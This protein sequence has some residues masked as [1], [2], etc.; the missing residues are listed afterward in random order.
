M[1]VDAY[2]R[3]LK[4]CIMIMIYQVCKFVGWLLLHSVDLIKLVDIH[5]SV[6]PFIHLSVCP[7][8]FFSDLS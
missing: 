2:S 8:K 5:M 1:P 3:K 4:L 7:Q 6:R